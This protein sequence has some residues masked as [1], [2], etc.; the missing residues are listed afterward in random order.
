MNQD[1]WHARIQAQKSTKK[2]VDICVNSFIAF[3][4][5]IS[6]IN[7]FNTIYS[8]MLIRKKD[9]LVLKSLGASNKKLNKIMN[10][11]CLFYGINAVI[12]GVFISIWILYVLYI[13]MVETSLL[14]FEIPIL[15]IIICIIALYL[16]IYLAL[17]KAKKQIDK[18]EIIEITK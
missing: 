13:R 2:V 5:L 6:A 9:F 16:L 10:L 12:F 7:I 17:N 4:A 14:A 3:L 1:D 15:N 18:D 11:E 8:S